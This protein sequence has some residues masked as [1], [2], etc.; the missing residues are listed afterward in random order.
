MDAIASLAL[1]CASS[2]SYAFFVLSKLPA[3]IHNSIYA[4][5]VSGDILRTLQIFVILFV[6]KTAQNSPKRQITGEY[7]ELNDVSEGKF[8]RNKGID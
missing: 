1:G 8:V 5:S 2:Y 3:C 4:R 6:S 7:G